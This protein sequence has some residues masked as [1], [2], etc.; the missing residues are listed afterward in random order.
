MTPSMNPPQLVR[1]PAPDPAKSNLLMFNLAVDADDP[2]LSFTTD[3]LNRLAAHFAR[4]D[5]I[6]MRTGRLAVAPNVHVY[7]VGKEKGYSE[8]RRAVEFYRLLFRLTGTTRYFAC[9]AHMMPL[10]AALG[11]PLLT[12][13]GIPITL[14]FTH[15]QKSIPLQA[16]AAFSHRIVT[17]A[18]DS[19]PFS[20]PKLRV[21]GH[22][23]DTEFFAPAPD[24]PPQ[25]DFTVVHVARV[26]PIKHQD[27]LIRAAAAVP[28]M[29]VMLVGEVP[30][31]TSEQYKTDLH[32]LADRMGVTDRVVFAGSQSKEGVRAILRSASAAV[33]LSPPGLFD[34]AA[35]E[36]MAVE[37]PTIASS[38][39]FR[40]VMGRHA[41]ALLIAAPEDHNTLAL[42]LAAI[43]RLPAEERR[44]MGARLRANV[45][46]QHSLDGLIE[47]LV[48]VL[49]DGE[50]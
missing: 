34:K 24:S 14:W 41:P 26:M 50:P 32:A 33:N 19:F 45:I 9:F 20:T 15:R 28:T 18:P 2:V 21:L 25:A 8:A 42:R 10:F 40:P 4:I 36:G 1:R 44:E 43:Q 16:A 7:S 38:E 37:V 29:R 49:I 3:W 31:D 13:R 11:G 35:L 23:V 5:V 30:P 47:R 48:R 17:A 22:G 12:A 46:A 39:A 6:T 27:T